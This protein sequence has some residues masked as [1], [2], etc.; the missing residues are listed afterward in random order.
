MVAEPP[1]RILR[2]ASGGDGVGTLADGRT[3]FVPRTAAGDLVTL[4]RL[5]RAKRFARAEVAEVVEPSPDRVEPPCPH[6]VRDDCGGCQLQHLALPAQLAAKQ[7][8]VG[9]A[10]RRIGK[11]ELPDPPVEEA[12]EAW[13]YRNKV[14]LA[15]AD[16]GRQVGFHRRGRPGSVFDLERCLLADDA[17]MKLWAVVRRHRELLPEGVEHLVLRRDGAGGLHLTARVRGQTAWQ[18]AA[19]LHR[20]LVRGSVPA[21]LWWHPEGGAP[22]AVAGSSEP[23]PA[24]V[25]EQV[26]P[27]MGNRV[28]AWALSQLG[29]VDGRRAWDLYAGVGDTSAALAAGGAEVHSVELDARAVREAERR[30]PEAGIRRH[31]GRAEDVVPALK[32]ADIVVTNPPRTGMD[33]RV[34]EAIAAAG[35]KTLVYISC[36]PATL[37]RDL[38]RMLA[39]FPASLPPRVVAVRAFDLFPQTAHVE[40]VAILEGSA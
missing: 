40:T 31:V 29:P 6:Y 22:R 34:T 20:E 7:S 19:R 35:P 25:F 9:E 12:A 36:D 32:P 1:V 28:R 30:G 8:M 39:R 13:G 2:I 11:L 3:V 27:A 24:D 17:L 18:A 26:H 21:V 14:T 10:L 16:G 15:V 5:V 4:D 38:S 33:E 23:Y 37:A